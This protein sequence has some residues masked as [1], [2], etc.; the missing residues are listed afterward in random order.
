M[1]G[2]PHECNLCTKLLNSMP[3]KSSPMDCIPTIVLKSCA[4]VFAPLIA[5]LAALCFDEGV[6]PTR[7]KV[8]SVTPLLKKKGLDC[9][10]VA[11]YR[12]ISNLHTIS[13]LVERLFLSRVINHVEQAPCFNRFQ[14]AY[15]RNHST[16][17]ALLR[18]LND[19]YC[20]ADNKSRTLLVQL[21]LSQHL[22]QLITALY[23]GDLNVRLVCPIRLFASFGHTLVAV[24]SMYVLVR[25]NRRPS[26]V[27]M[28]CHRARFW[29]LSYTLCM[30]RRSLVS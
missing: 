11:N 20:S 12:P 2:H 22:I 17:T 3:A 15:R 24:L 30:S 19:A 4:D 27:N 18:M 9:D 10:D 1:T 28:E 8:A 14:S 16:E 26:C 29:D 21:D 25:N 23:S 13:K 6:F 7:F 5:R